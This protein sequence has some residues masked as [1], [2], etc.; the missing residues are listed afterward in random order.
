MSHTVVLE[1]DGVAYDD[2]ALEG[3][4]IQWGRQSVQDQPEPTSCSVSFV[5]ESTLGTVDV[6]D[7][8]IGAQIKIEI[9][10][11]GQPTLRRFFGIIT[12]VDVNHETI[13]AACVATG[14]Y[15]MRQQAYTESDQGYYYITQDTVAENLFA[16]Y[17]IAGFQGGMDMTFNPPASSTR[18]PYISYDA[19]WPLGFPQ[20]SWIMSCPTGSAPVTYPVSDWMREYA[21][22][23]PSGVIWENMLEVLAQDNVN[24]VFDG[25]LAR[26]KPLTA[27]VVLTSD[28][29]M[30]DWVSSRDLGLFCTSSEIGYSGGA[31][32]A[33]P[34]GYEYLSTGRKSYDSALTATWGSFAKNYS[35]NLVQAADAQTLAKVNVQNGEV[36]G[37]VTQVTVPLAT[38]TAA[39]QSTLVTNLLIGSLWE[40]PTLATGLPTLYFLEGYTETINRA[41]WT[42]RLMLSDPSNSWYGQRWQ[43]VT[44]T[45]QWDQVGATTTWIDLRGQE[46]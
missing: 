13:V 12:D 1:I 14:I 10:P 17:T 45:L 16:V 27:D 34:E 19:N 3:V 36:P 7:I 32:S 29:I 9:T 21:E 8:K 4:T 11:S 46:L 5:R 6:N 15:V 42:L 22:S 43:D 35:V 2:K 38:L 24:V 28:E 39:R 41:D 30:L 37:Y 40:T 44:A 26:D 25:Q 20:T 33:S 23:T 18:Y 31:T